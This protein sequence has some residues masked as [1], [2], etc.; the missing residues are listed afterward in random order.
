MEK[1][2]EKKIKSLDSKTRKKIE[3]VF[4][5]MNESISVLYDLATRDEK[6]GLYNINFFN[7]VFDMEF[8]KAKRGHEKLSL[9]IADIDFFKKI[10]DTYGHIR[11][12]DLLK[13]LADL[14]KRELRKS[15]VVAR[16]G[17][18]EFIILL[19]ETSIT[20]AKRL[21]ARL[22]NSIKKDPVLKKHNLTVSIGLTEY[23]KGDTKKRMRERAD[24]ALYRAKHTGRDRIVVM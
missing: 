19:T 10:N 14:M 8:E 2:L 5:L 1:H 17:G 12:D 16:F 15:D 22:R 9:L 21:T 18:E 24:K 13:R 20:K 11:A 3:T 23:K 6:T 4:Q 7:N